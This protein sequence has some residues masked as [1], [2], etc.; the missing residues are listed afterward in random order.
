MTIRIT[1]HAVLRWLERVH[2]VDVEGFRQKLLD[3]V[4][5]AAVVGGSIG[6]RFT[7][8]RAEGNYIIDNNT[9]IT[10]TPPGQRVYQSREEEA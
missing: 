1:D 9:L 2:G 6:K 5:A 8:K 3:D 7:L 10:V 4:E